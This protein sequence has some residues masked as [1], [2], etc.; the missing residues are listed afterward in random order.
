MNP[1]PHWAKSRLPIF[2]RC[3]EDQLS[4]NFQNFWKM[5]FQ[6]WL[7]TLEDCLSTSFCL[8]EDELLYFSN[9][10]KDGLTNLLKYVENSSSNNFLY[11]ERRTYPSFKSFEIWTFDF[12]KRCRKLIYR[13]LS[14]FRNMN[15]SYLS[16]IFKFELS[17]FQKDVENS[18]IDVFQFFE[19]RTSPI[20]RKFLNLNFQIFKK[21]SKTRI[22]ISQLFER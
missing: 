16:K 9:I 8:S 22:S 12:S 13:H 5:N 7:K 17:I 19:I 4:T 1:S 3:W 18:F 10:S 11:F 6:I 15:F 21:M 14:I 2:E 20:F